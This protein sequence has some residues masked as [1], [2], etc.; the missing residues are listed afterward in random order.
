MGLLTGLLR[1]GC[2]ILGF[3]GVSIDFR[4]IIPWLLGLVVVYGPGRTGLDKLVVVV[5]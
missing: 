5:L 4:S 1:W 2:A 3:L